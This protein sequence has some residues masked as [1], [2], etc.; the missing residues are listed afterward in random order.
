MPQLAGGSPI[1]SQQCFSESIGQIINCIPAESSGQDVVEWSQGAYKSGNALGMGW[2][3]SFYLSLSPW[4]ECLGN[5][6]GTYLLLDLQFFS[7]PLEEFSALNYKV[8]W[9]GF[10]DMFIMMSSHYSHKLQI[11]F[12]IMK[13]RRESM[14]NFN[15]VRIWFMSVLLWS[16]ALHIQVVKTPYTLPL[17]AF[18]YSM[19]RYTCTC[20]DL[21]VIFAGKKYDTTIRKICC[22][23]ICALK[24]LPFWAC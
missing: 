8:N 19:Q 12:S 17:C 5:W 16:E 21:C 20:K 9:K 24:I 1:P 10:S 6:M 11:F 13:K 3:L 18:V 7:Q 22:N 23:S 2:L 14:F 15:T 4:Q